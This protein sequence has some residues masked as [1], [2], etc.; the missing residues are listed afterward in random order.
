MRTRRGRLSAG[1]VPFVFLTVGACL[2]AAL[3]SPAAAGAQAHDM[4]AMASTTALP[5]NIPDFCA[6]STIAS[7][8]SGA[9]SN[10]S[11]WSP[12]RVPAA[13]DIV[14]VASGTTVT[15]DIVSDVALP[16][17]AVNGRLTFRTDV[18]TRIKVGTFM[19]MAAGN[20]D[21]GTAATPVAAGVTAE[22]VI[23]NQP[24]N[25]TAD[26]EQFGTAL[27][28]LGKVRMH[29]AIKT[30]TFSRVTV[31]PVKGATTVTLEQAVTGWRVGDR[32]IIPDTRHLHWDEVSNWRIIAPQWE[33]RTVA[34]ISTDGKVITLN[35]GLTRSSRRADGSGAPALPAASRQPVAQSFRPTIG[36]AGAGRDLHDA[37]TST[38][39]MRV[40]DLGRT[41]ADAPTRIQSAA[42]DAPAS[43]DGPA[44][45]PASGYRTLVSSTIDSR[46]T[47]HRRCHRLTTHTGRGQRSTLARAARP[48]TARNFVI[49]HLAAVPRHGGASATTR[50]RVS[51]SEPNNYVHHNVAANSRRRAEHRTATSISLSAP[52]TPWGQ[53][54]AAYVTRDGNT[55]PILEFSNNEVYGASQGGLTYWWVSSQDPIAAANPLESVFK[56]LKI[57]HVYN[58][59]IY[60]Y[61]SARVTFDGLTILGEDPDL[62]ACCDFHGE[63][64]AATD[65]RIVNADIEG[66]NIG[67][68]WSAPAPACRS[69]SAAHCTTTSTWWCERCTRRTAPAGCRR[70]P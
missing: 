16:C 30:P 9:W 32:V 37:P 57:W 38:S 59:G 8:T 44:A 23:A 40:P 62:A 47:D 33:E 10:P 29:G 70:A 53:D 39:G 41:I 21:V 61:P 42:T 31:E 54:M 63:D 17:V 52:E 14:N 2:T 20:L 27:I 45:T 50:V 3:L 22:I 6:T 13:T 24:L 12:A 34:A 4:G 28:G 43:P 5:H 69:W 65:I 55:L 18:N 58:V 1:N 25:T 56:D 60:H 68:R 66:M 46:S 67:I 7:V 35:A 49:D 51:G 48:R 19:V 36:G 64:Y 15:Y 26:P 11:T